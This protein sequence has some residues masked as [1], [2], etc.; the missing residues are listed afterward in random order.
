MGKIWARPILEIT[1]VLMAV[2][3]VSVIRPFT[4]FYKQAAFSDAFQTFLSKS[5]SGTVTSLMLPLIVMCAVLLSLSFARDY[6]SGLMQSILSTPVSR[7]SFFVVKF[8]AV[9]LPLTLLS[10]FFTT[11]F[12]GIT[13]Y[14]NPWLVLHF[15]FFAL[16]VSFLSLMFCGSL[17]ILVALIIKRVI[18][19]VLTALLANFFL[20]FLTLIDIQ[21]A[22][23]TFGAWFADHLCLTPYNGSLVFLDKLLGIQP[24]VPFGLSE[25]LVSSISVGGFG[26]LTIFW[27]CILVV[28][29]F[30]YFCRR[31]EMCE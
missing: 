15:S 4:E 27:A 5:V 26:V 7:K 11:F 20:V 28:P 10:W 24:S 31:F 18:P 9:V 6:E 30:V 12:V 21:Y 3:S 25:P 17:G 19:A 8:F 13:F 1:V 23:Y 16:P 2:M 29:L 14:S 22:Y